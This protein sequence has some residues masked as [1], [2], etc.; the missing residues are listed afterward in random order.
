[1]R[2]VFLGPPGVGKGTHASLLAK[3]L[4]I[5]H[6]STGDIFREILKSPS[7][8]RD[9]LR[10]YIV[11]GSLVPDNI[12]FETVKKVLSDS[13]NKE[14]WLLDG[15]PRNRNQAELL[16]NFL[17]SRGEELDY[18]IYLYASMET[19]ITR[20]SNR[21]VCSECGAIFNIV[22]NPPKKDNICDRCGGALIQREDDKEETIKKRIAI[23]EKEFKPLK[24]YYKK[25][26]I[27]IEVAAEG[28]LSDI[29]GRI[30]E[31]LRIG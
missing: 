18:A 3:D 15:Y 4:G 12:V 11:S 2:I 24:D 13:K 21:R 22:N 27:L 7:P 9:E 1:M 6:Y 29:A 17:D 30:R 25:R 10:K 16:D 31:G 28:E 8:L 19:L 26:E 20:L 5:P 23:F 14:G